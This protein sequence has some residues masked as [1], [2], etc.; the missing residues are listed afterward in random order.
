MSNFFESIPKHFMNAI[1][2]LA[3][4]LAMTL[5]SIS[6]VSVTLFL[7][8]LFLILA[9][10]VD[11]FADHVE[12]SLK[13][14]VSIDSLVDDKQ[15]K[16]M[17]EEIKKMQGVKSVEFSSKED[18]L[19]IL[20]EESGSVFERYKDN[21]PMPNTFVVEV[22]NANEIPKV[23]KQLNELEGI[24]NAQ[25]GGSGI[26]D[27][28]S[29]FETIRYGGAAFILALGILAVFLITNTIKMTIYTRK[30]EISIM[31]NV[32]AGNWY[33]KAP[34]MF[35][36]MFIGFIGAIIPSLLTIFGY[37]LLYNGLHGQFV[38]NMFVLKSPFPFTFLITGILLLSGMV[39]GMLGSFFAT[40]KYLRW[41][42]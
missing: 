24:E 1:K 7:M 22:D 32:G 34:F 28:I 18:E 3:R 39:V 35:E 5:S 38:S 17:Q 8:T 19:N 20:I 26:K 15:I 25:Y 14:H 16:N 40:T 13:I 21:N 11:S 2:N 30:T 36:G 6:A 31:R 41:R 33:I 4:H 42:R 9:A 27:M 37:Q 23:T 29:I 12:S 10:N